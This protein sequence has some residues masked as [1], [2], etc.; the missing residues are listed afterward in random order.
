MRG[1]LVF[2][3]FPIP[4][5]LAQPLGQLSYWYPIVII[6]IVGAAHQ[7]WSANL[8]SVGSNLFPRESV[9]T[10]TGINSLAGGLSVGLI[11]LTSGKLFRYTEVTQTCYVGFQGKAAGYFMVFSY[12]A[13]AYLVGWCMLRLFTTRVKRP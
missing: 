6:G 5:L 3:A 7:S 2:A 12:C 8:Y 9:A 13:V 1:M 10:I 11:N 4:A